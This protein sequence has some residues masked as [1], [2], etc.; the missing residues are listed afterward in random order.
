MAA[1]PASWANKTTSAPEQPSV[2]SAMCFKSTSCSSRFIFLVLLIRISTI[3]T[4]FNSST[5]SISFN[6]EVKTLLEAEVE[7]PPL[8]R[9]EERASIS[10]KKMIE[11]EAAL[12]FLKISR[13]AFS[14]SPTYLLKISGPLT[15]RKFTPDSVARALAVSVLEQPGGP[16]SRTPFGEETPNLLKVSEASSGNWI[17][18]FNFC[19][20]SS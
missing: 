19:F 9:S 2:N 17:I 12:A 3:T 7:P 18:S 16:Y 4:P 6:R 20:N 14:D 10:S 5:P 1:N 8:A 13:I 11:G 15:A